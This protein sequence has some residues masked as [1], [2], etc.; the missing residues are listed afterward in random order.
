LTVPALQ[1]L[2]NH[3]RGY[4]AA[5]AGDLEQPS[6]ESGE[7]LS[8]SEY[9]DLERYGIIGDLGT[10]ALIGDD[11]SIDWCCFPHIESP[12]I[13]AAIL[14]HARGG[15]FS[16]TPSGQFTSKQQYIPDTNVLVTTFKTE[17]GTAKLTD[18]MLLKSEPAA[19]DRAHPIIY[20][21]LA[22]S[23]GS[24]EFDI[25]YSPRFNYAR[26]A[27]DLIFVGGGIEAISNDSKLFLQSDVKLTVEKE[28]AAA[29]F[30]LDQGEE[31]WF[32]LHYRDREHRSSA[33]CAE[34][35]EAT[36]KFWRD[37]VHKTS[38]NTKLFDGP[39]RDLVIRS[40]LVL[41]LLAHKDAGAICAAATTSLPECIGGERNWDYRYGWIRDASFTVQ[42]LY[43]AGHYDEARKHLRWF[44]D[45]CRR[46]PDPA[47]IQTMYG[48]H[49]E[50]NLHEEELSHLE[51][52]RKSRPVRIGNAA[53]KQKQLD[54]YG[55]LINAIY[56]TE[57]YGD[58][59]PEGELEFII[60]I[61]DYVSENWN[62]PDSGIWEV[63]GGPRHFVYSK[64]MCWVALDRG[65]KIAKRRKYDTHVEEWKKVRDEIK[66]AIIEKG[67]DE[68]LGSFV[69]SYGSKTLDATGL[70]IPV[71]GLLP[72]DD[73][74]V[75]NTIDSI[76]SKLT[77]K[78][79]LVYR[80]QGQ[81]GLQ[82]RE[83]AFLLCSFWLVKAL[84]LSN[85]IPEAEEILTKVTKFAGGTGLFSEEIDPET[86]K[87][88]G[89]LPQAFSH[90][91][92]INSVLY[93][94]HML[95]KSH[96]GPAPS[97]TNASD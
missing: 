44:V 35:L 94:G 38:G 64:L 66:R 71:M 2:G 52:Y 50:R 39:W 86:G 24:V 15:R 30:T 34:E 31:A 25:H 22:C 82:G 58:G 67:Y 60:R 63:R 81:D 59:I 79:G 43:N 26:D 95:G 75:Q 1:S 70:L 51:G 33:S 48:M 96:V 40:G 69:Q 85:R 49:G 3:R 65:I 45:I 73:A 29:R 16:I 78:S 17:T 42:A 62:T 84:A 10:C 9:K 21:R 97:G 47:Q 57:R 93:L 68:E 55:E 54:I 77:T 91:G 41:K 13:F 87:Q 32:L 92:L 28:S 36:L 18:F 14:D 23:A 61:V 56:E 88:L 12:S 20:R 5:E 53:A 76:L 7:A 80:Y 19:A 11:G 4:N 74:R 83:G 90:V 72:S 6:I 46:N 37:W 89:N 27:T 8:M